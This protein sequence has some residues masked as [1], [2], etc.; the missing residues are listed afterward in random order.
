MG[1]PIRRYRNDG[2]LFSPKYSLDTIIG[3]CQQHISCSATY[4]WGPLVP[5]RGVTFLMR[6]V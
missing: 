1:S 3:M 2:A 6:F 5:V 4:S